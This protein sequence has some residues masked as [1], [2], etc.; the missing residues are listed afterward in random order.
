MNQSLGTTWR[1]VAGWVEANSQRLREHPSNMW[2]YWCTSP[3][4]RCVLRR[5]NTSWIPAAFEDLLRLNRINTYY[6]PLR[7][8]SYLWSV[9]RLG[10]LYCYDQP[11]CRVQQSYH[12]ASIDRGV[13]T[14]GLSVSPPCGLAPATWAVKAAFVSC[15][16]TSLADLADPP[17]ICIVDTRP[18]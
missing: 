4:F 5:Q 11:R 1:P 9:T 8:D 16:C 15:S 12:D 17:W 7:R 10:D 13:G 6:V 14:L 3:N 18:A 2:C